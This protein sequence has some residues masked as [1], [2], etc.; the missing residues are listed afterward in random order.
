MPN[1]NT[2]SLALRRKRL[3]YEQKQIALLLGHK[4]I[5]Q[6][7]RYETGQRTPG[8]KEA[9]K[10]SMLYGIPIGALFSRYFSRCRE[11]VEKAIKQSGLASKI[12]LENAAKIDF[13]SYLEMLNSNRI[14]ES[15]ADKIRHHIKVLIE[16][17]SRKILGN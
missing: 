4:T 12:N 15:G 9:V 7:S 2:S 6:I 5:Y 17:R 14:S 13:C 10:L 16:E 1:I 8:L 3:G 11:E